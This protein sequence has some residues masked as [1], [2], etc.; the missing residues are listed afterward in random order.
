MVRTKININ[1]DDRGV[2]INF[3]TGFRWNDF[4][5]R[6]VANVIGT[7]SAQN[8]DAVLNTSIFQRYE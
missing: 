2:K 5:Y 6:S 3:M 4:N 7:V 1:S 8:A